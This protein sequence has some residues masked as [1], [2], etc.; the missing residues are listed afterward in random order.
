MMNVLLM[1]LTLDNFGSIVHPNKTQFL[2]KQI[3]ICLGF[4]L[5][6]REMSVRLTDE[7]TKKVASACNY[8]LHTRVYTIREVATVLGTLVSIFPGVMHGPLKYKGLEYDKIALKINKGD[9]DKTMHMSLS[10]SAK[11]EPKWWLQNV[12][13]SFHMVALIMSFILMYH[14]LVGVLFLNN[15]IPV[16]TGLV[17]NNST[18]FRVVCS[19]LETIKFL[20]TQTKC[21]F[22]L[23]N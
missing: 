19:L 12:Q 23:N 3:T 18:I 14:L 15:H 4:I 11:D 13:I 10:S 22:S 8:L 1:S 20:Q 17:L 7:K 9:Y 5:N 16:D 21:T 2:P 6:S